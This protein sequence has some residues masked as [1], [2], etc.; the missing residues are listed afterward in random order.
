M[1]DE[2]TTN[3]ER[4]LARA[5]APQ[6]PA[7]LPLGQGSTLDLSLLTEE[8]KQA[9][10]MDNARNRI[11]MARRA[12]ELAVD[13]RAL[14]ETLRTMSD[15]T[16][17]VTTSGDSVT[18]SHTQTTAIGRTEILM[19][20]TERAESGKLTKSQTGERDWTPFYVIGGLIVIALIG[21]AA[22]GG[23]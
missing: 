3:D 11:D 2:E 9:L 8:Q 18:I 16:R 13:V 4:A 7:T 23:R 1:A 22:V 21:M 14:D 6:P 17:N 19:G 12:E 5:E 20:N 10:V 15:T